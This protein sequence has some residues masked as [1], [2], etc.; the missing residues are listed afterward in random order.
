MNNLES[1]EEE[2]EELQV[3]ENINTFVLRYPEHYR[4]YLIRALK[5][6]DSIEKALKDLEHFNL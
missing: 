2:K 4:S 1:K 6:G 5:E 3:I